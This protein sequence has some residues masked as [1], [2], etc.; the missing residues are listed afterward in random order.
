MEKSSCRERTIKLK[1]PDEKFNHF[2]ARPHLPLAFFERYQ[3]LFQTFLEENLPKNKF[4]KRIFPFS[5]QPSKNSDQYK[6]RRQGTQ[7][8]RQRFDGSVSKVL[9]K[10]RLSGGVR[11]IGDDR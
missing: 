10:Q 5:E 11:G 7:E 8:Q 3:F 1:V 9:C 6:R 4:F 2:Y